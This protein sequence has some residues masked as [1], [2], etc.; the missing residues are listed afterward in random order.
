LDPGTR[1]FQL[2]SPQVTETPPGNS[3][4][5]YNIVHIDW[6]TGRAQVEQPKVQ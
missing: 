3:T 4:N 6:L 5:I 1:M 2:N